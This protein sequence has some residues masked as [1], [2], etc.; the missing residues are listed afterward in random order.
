MWYKK[1]DNL[2]WKVKQINEKLTKDMLHIFLQNK[3]GKKFKLWQKIN[4]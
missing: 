4:N 2:P 3:K 1:A